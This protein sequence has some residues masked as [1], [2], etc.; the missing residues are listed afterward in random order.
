M[1]IDSHCHI[2][3][4]RFDADRE[5]MIQRARDAGIEH[6]VTIGFDLKTSRAAVALAQKYPFISA[7][8]GV[9]PHEVKH[10]QDNWNDELRALAKSE[11]VVAYGE[12]G[13]DYHYDH[14]P[15]D[16]QRAR[17]REQVQLAR[18]LYLPIII[19]TREAQE[20]TIAILQEEKAGA[21]GGVFHC[22]SGDAWLAKD[23]LDLGF[24]LSF[25]GV[26]T[27]Q[28]ATMLRDIAKTVPL[29]RILVETDSPYLTPV[30]H[31]GKRNE[32]SYVRHVAEK[33]A[34]LHGLSAQDVEDATTQNTKRLFGIK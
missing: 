9:H 24:Y 20:D 2:D 32:P 21:L 31:R 22:F 11:R 10:I 28:N 25:S 26:I 23:A 13:L 6:F 29:D 15:R 1:L 16:V 33:L 27:F 12:I 18:E 34:D 19:H 5:A 17:F 4:A 14:S 3:D 30:P 8:V 7:T